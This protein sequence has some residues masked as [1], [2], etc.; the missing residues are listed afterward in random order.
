[1]PSG[2]HLK[3]KGP[4]VLWIKEHMNYQGD[5]CLTWPYTIDPF[6]G[7]G[8]C[9]YNGKLYWAHRLMCEFVHGDAPEDR[10]QAAHSCGNGHLGCCNPRH[11]SWKTNSE[12]QIERREHGRPEG[13]KGTRTYLTPDQISEIRTSKG[14]IPQLKLADKFGV[15][16]GTIEYWQRHNRAPRPFSINPNNIKRRSNRS[17]V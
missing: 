2:E 17:A 6:Y 16:R 8:R 10:P 15:K 11:L 7:R 14:I 12:N 9:S 13:G 3:G 5:D 4:G 1:M